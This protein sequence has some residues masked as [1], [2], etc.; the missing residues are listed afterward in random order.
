VDNYSAGAAARAFEALLAAG[1][2]APAE[3]R[4]SAGRQY[5]PVNVQVARR[6]LEA[7]MAANQWCPARLKSWLAR[8]E[9]ALATT[10]AAIFVG[11]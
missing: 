5:A 2:L 3:G 9:G 10:A 1:L 11:G 6:E 4:L 8:P 7:G